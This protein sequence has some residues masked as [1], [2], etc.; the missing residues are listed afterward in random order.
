MEVGE[1]P[2]E[3]T[4]TIASQEHSV[5]HACVGHRRR[6]KQWGLNNPSLDEVEHTSKEDAL[7]FETTLVICIRKHE[8]YILQDAQEVLLKEGVANGGI[9]C[10][11]KII[12]DLKADCCE[13]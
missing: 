9:C 2:L 12:E 11:S 4:R 5:R 10:T 3:K 7:K 8:E 13:E 6:I 1:S